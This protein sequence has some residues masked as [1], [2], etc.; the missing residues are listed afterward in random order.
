MFG[1]SETIEIEVELF[2]ILI[3]GAIANKVSI[4]SQWDEIITQHESIYPK[5]PPIIWEVRPVINPSVL[6]RVK[7][8]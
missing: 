6:C 4:W 5:H 2:G 1:L 8:D 3:R 7:F